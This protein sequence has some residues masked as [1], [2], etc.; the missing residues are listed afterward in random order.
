LK[1]ILNQ[2]L[3]RVQQMPAVSPNTLRILKLASDP[4]YE[5]RTMA[6][7]V[8][9]DITLSTA[10][11]RVVNSAMFG[12]LSPVTSI[13]KAV[14]YLG[15]REIVNVAMHTGFR[16]LYSAPLS[17]YSAEAGD[18]WTH[19]LRTAIASMLLAKSLQK[20]ETTDAAYTAGLLH[21][22]GKVITSDFLKVSLSDVLHSLS[23]GDNS[24]FPTIEKNL[25]SMDHTEIGQLLAEKWKIPTKIE[26]VIRY[27]HAPGEA[28]EEFRELCSMVHIGDVLA[29]LGGYG[30]GFD[31]LSYRID[32]S[33]WNILKMNDE[34]VSRLMLDID[35]E[36]EKAQKKLTGI[37]AEE[38]A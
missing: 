1:A 8:A 26:T 38:T 28:P 22:I 19:S 25:I 34:T 21:D 16:G 5:T 33:V 30:T 20:S 17:G 4:Y 24:D 3:D 29:M 10:C 2:V 37:F 13:E 6:D 27:H 31:T 32:P 9:I 36:F 14:A 7:L 15:R 23:R 11:L 18:L 35:T 12:L